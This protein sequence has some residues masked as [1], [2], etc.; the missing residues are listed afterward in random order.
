MRSIIFILLT[1]SLTSFTTFSAEHTEKLFSKSQLLETNDYGKIVWYNLVTPNIEDS[2]QF[3]GSIFDWTFQDIDLKGQKFTIIKY[4][5]T[6]I[7]SM[8]ELPKA[9]ASLWLA[10]VS[11]SDI[12]GIIKKYTDNKGKL[13]I[14][15]FNVSGTGEQVILEGPLGEKM[16]Y[17]QNPASPVSFIDNGPNQW[18]WAELWSTNAETS[19]VFYESV[20]NSNTTASEVEERPYWYFENDGEKVAGMITNPVE[21]SN[22]QWVPYIN[23][24]DITK[25]NKKLEALDANIMLAPKNTK[26]ESIL[27]FQDPHGATICA[28]N[29]SN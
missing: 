15:S 2:K 6:L 5:T 4:N 19:K 20:W 9:D 1:F 7:G 16:A 18:I 13:L 8:L 3:Y 11:V 26:N 10:S 21:G 24:A 29:Y 27:I 12:K 17:I 25:L 28:Q 23:M 22:T 14:N